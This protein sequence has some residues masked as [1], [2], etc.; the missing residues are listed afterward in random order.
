MYLI[1]SVY[2][3]RLNKSQVKFLIQ[4]EKYEN[5]EIEKNFKI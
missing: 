2:N 4:Y 5:V 3:V 1:F